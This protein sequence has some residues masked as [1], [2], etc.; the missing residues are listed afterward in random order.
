[1][2]VT[3]IDA[4]A[5]VDELTIAGLKSAPSIKIRPPRIAD[6]PVSLECRLHTTV[7]LGPDQI[8]LIGRI[9]HAHV[10]DNFV[11][12]PHEPAFNTPALRLIGGM[13]GAKWYTRTSDLFAMERPTWAEWQRIGNVK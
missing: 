10:A 1:M 7:P 12:D 2:N 8:F 13:H 6:S 3:C 4:P 9:V 5:N 11:V